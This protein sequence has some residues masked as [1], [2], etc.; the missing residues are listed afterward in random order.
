MK[1]FMQTKL[2]NSSKIAQNHQD[3]GFSLI[4]V[5]VVVLMIGILAAIAAPSWLA[6][7]QRQRLNKA[8]DAVLTVLKDAQQKAKKT[9]LSYSVSLRNF[10]R[11]VQIALYPTSTSTESLDD[12]WQN[13]GQDL[14]LPEG[15]I[16]LVED[17]SPVLT[18]DYMGT[19]AKNTDFGTPAEGSTEVPG[20]KL[21]LAVAQGSNDTPTNVKRCVIIKT[22]LGAMSTE[23][24]A[25]CDS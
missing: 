2:L 5:L 17:P 4:E 13:L 15:A 6:F 23:D 7:V 24:D 12:Y 19:L 22:L 20:L 18:F 9:K 25:N 11:R 21:V 8:N 1:N 14:Q 3:S 10:E 16:V